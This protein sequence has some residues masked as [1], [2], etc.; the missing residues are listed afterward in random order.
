MAQFI[1]I[2]LPVASLRGVVTQRRKLIQLLG[3]LHALQ[4]RPRGFQGQETQTGQ[5]GQHHLALYDR[6]KR[7]R[8]R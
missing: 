2:N 6:R 5:T 8:D 1:A 4:N 3:S 7:S